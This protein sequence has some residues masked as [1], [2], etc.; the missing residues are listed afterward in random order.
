MGPE[1]RAQVLSAGRAIVHRAERRV[2][3][4]DHGSISLDVEGLPDDGAAIEAF[5]FPAE[6]ST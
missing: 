6:A 1:E 2:E 3:L 5:L 4:Y